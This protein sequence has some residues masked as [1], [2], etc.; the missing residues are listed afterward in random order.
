MP[1]TAA[2]EGSV[3]ANRMRLAAALEILAGL[4]GDQDVVVTT[5]GAAREWPRLTQHP[6]DFH[7]IP[8]TMGGGLP[9]GLGIALA[10]PHREVLVLSGDGSLLMSLGALVTIVDSGA[11][12]LSVVLI[13][14]GVY[15]VTGGQKTA[16]AGAGTD[17]AQLARACGFSNVTQFSDLDDFRQRVNG[18]LQGRG[19]RFL[20]MMVEPVLEDYALAPPGPMHDRLGRFRQALREG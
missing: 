19:P 16:A 13:D 10:Q 6:L 17:F 3:G 20:R 18:V 2:G 4:R 12:N 15:E 1:D 14:N 8:S 11:T 5:M 9:L 7:Y